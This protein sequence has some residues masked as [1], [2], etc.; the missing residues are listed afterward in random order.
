MKRNL[1]LMLCVLPVFLFGEA[2][3]ESLIGNLGSDGASGGMSNAFTSVESPYSLIF[4]PSLVRAN[5]AISLTYMHDVLQYGADYDAGTSVFTFGLPF[6]KGSKNNSVAAGFYFLSEE[7]IPVTEAGNDTIGGTNFVNIVYKG[8]TSYSMSQLDFAV[9]RKVVDFNIGFSYSYIYGS[10]YDVKGK[11]NNLGIGVGYNKSLNNKIISGFGMGAS[12]R[13]FTYLKW[14]NGVIDTLDCNFRIGMNIRLFEGI[15]NA[16]DD[17][18]LMT[19]DMVQN[20]NPNRFTPS[21][22]I[23]AEWKVFGLIP[24]RVGLNNGHY[25]AGVGFKTKYIDF[26][27]AFISNPVISSAHKFSITVKL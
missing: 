24:V 11:G 7:G 5:R 21:Y 23:G 2:G 12:Y 27:Y 8:V 19:F 6:D 10:M 4:N 25:T 17:G 14:N 18:I 16:L 1:I 22:E 20:G 9:N 13:H 3:T 26:D 15:T